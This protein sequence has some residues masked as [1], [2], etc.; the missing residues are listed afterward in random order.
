MGVGLVNRLFCAIEGNS[1]YSI[2]LP[3][4]EGIEG[5]F[6]TRRILAATSNHGGKTVC[7]SLLLNCGGHGGEIRV[8][9][10]WYDEADGIGPCVA[11]RACLGIWAVIELFSCLFYARAGG[12]GNS[13]VSCQ[14]ARGGGNGH[15]GSSGYVLEGGCGHFGS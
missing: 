3:L 14:C 5:A 6:Q 7:I 12:Y 9:Q 10:A 8:V 13:W 4:R 2:D 15:P 11:Q 1:N